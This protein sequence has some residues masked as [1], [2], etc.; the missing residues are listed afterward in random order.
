MSVML[1][2]YR[3]MGLLSSATLYSLAH[4]VCRAPRIV[5][6]SV[7]DYLAIGTR[8]PRWRGRLKAPCHFQVDSSHY[9]KKK[10]LRQPRSWDREMAPE[11]MIHHRLPPTGFKRA[12]RIEIDLLQGL[13]AGTG[14]VTPQRKVESEIVPKKQEVTTSVER[15]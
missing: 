11:H 1:H 2:V 10:V 14:V 4:F 6:E 13:C 5:H 8:S 15:M 12:P 3:K 7:I 9:Q